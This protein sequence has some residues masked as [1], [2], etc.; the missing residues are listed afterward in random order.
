MAR[1]SYPISVCIP[2]Y[3]Y[4]R[5]LKDAVGSC[6]QQD[7]DFEIVVLDNCSRDDTPLLREQFIGDPRIKWHRNETVLPIHDNWNKAISLATR[8]YVKQLHADDMLS[9][10]CIV[11]MGAMITAKPHVAYHGHLAEIIDEHGKVLRKH[12]P[13]SDEIEVAEV[14]GSE[15]LRRKLHS[16]IRFREPS[17][18][19][20]LKEAWEKVGGY[21]YKFRFM[22]DVAFTVSMLSQFHCATWNKYLVRLRRHGTSDG[23]QLPMEMSLQELKAFVEKIRV[24]MGKDFSDRDKAAGQ[25]L[26]LYKMLELVGGRF[27]RQ[28]GAASKFFAENIELLAVGPRTYFHLSKLLKNRLFYGD[29]QQKFRP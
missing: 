21:D 15:G 18:N 24:L 7:A 8:K 20:F 3:N 22:S 28:P 29:Q 6:I 1:P 2:S 12:H 25:G 4:Y 27:R 19:F 11:Q 17:C 10:D 16:Q 13:F 26:T 23:T 5:F 9:P 14:T